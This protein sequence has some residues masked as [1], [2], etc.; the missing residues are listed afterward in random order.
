MATTTTYGNQAK[1]QHHFKDNEGLIAQLIA[2]SLGNSSCV[3]LCT[4]KRCFKQQ[5]KVEALNTVRPSLRW[6][7]ENLSG[8]TPVRIEQGQNHGEL[9]P[10]CKK[11]L[12]LQEVTLLLQL[13]DLLGVK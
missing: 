3:R 4:S 11:R 10:G 9:L 1:A 7:G 13:G 8:N 6:G 2:G 12:Q 5:H